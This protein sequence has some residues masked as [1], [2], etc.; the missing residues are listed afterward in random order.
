MFSHFSLFG[1]LQYLHVIVA[2]FA[3][4]K[5]GNLDLQNHVTG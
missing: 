4:Q 2:L 3:D 1:P 5:V